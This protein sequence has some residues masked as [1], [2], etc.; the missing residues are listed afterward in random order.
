[1]RV[2]ESRKRGHSRLVFFFSVW[3]FMYV[4]ARRE[5]EERRQGRQ[6]VGRGV[7]T[8]S[9]PPGRKEGESELQTTL[10]LEKK[11]RK[12]RKINVKRG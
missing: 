3:Y 9:T 2:W 1:M 7:H 8:S 5:E 6:A 11:E 12:K 10:L 4:R